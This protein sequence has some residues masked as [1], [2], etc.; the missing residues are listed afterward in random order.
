MM[1][2]P[3]LKAV[4]LRLACLSLTLL[5]GVA[6]THVVNR[7]WVRFEAVAS[8]AIVVRH[9]GR[10]VLL[11]YVSSDGVNLIAQRVDFPSEKE[12][13]GHYLS[14]ISKSSEILSR[15]LIRDQEGSLVVGE[16]VVGFFRGEDGLA[17]PTMICQD[18]SLVYVTS[19]T[20]LRHLMIFE[21]AHRRY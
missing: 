13:R 10:G 12:A 15:E 9:C 1:R 4:M 20:S 21:N 14:L 3:L 7:V 18:G 17:V 2:R 5:I 6:V 16:R 11:S 19:S 8:G